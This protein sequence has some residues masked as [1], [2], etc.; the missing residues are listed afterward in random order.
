MEYENLMYG[1]NA[2]ALFKLE[3]ITKNRKLK[4]T[5]S[6]IPSAD[7]QI[8]KNK[9]KEKLR[10]GEVRV[11]GCDVALMGGD[12]N[13]ATVFTCV[14]LIPHGDKYIRKVSYIETMEGQH[15]DNQAIR[16]KQLFEDFQASYVAL[17]CHGNGISIYDQLVKV[18]Y[19]EQRD[20]EYEAW[21]SYN[22]EEMKSRAKSINPLPV[23]FSIKAG[24]RL[25]HEI[26]SSLR[27]NLQNS[28]IELLI[29]E[30]DAKEMLSEKKDY[31]NKS[32]EDRALA[33]MPYLQTTSLAN[34]LVN[35]E[36]E[37]VGG[38]IKI[39]EKSGK[40]KD[41]YSSLAYANYLAKTLEANLLKVDEYDD[42]DELV[43]Y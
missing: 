11:I 36:R 15:T 6:P 34:E 5:F 3:D 8:L 21:C 24:S 32:P 26:A 4:N 7:Y 43:Y 22:D 31:Q 39:K 10:E 18:M 33:V 38:F 37:I 30:M 27:V 14:R 9:R 17:D 28:N 19:D 2:D 13:D 42:D 29:S 25:N 16:L 41:R 35:L 12:K 20:V 40:R 1:Q 23:V